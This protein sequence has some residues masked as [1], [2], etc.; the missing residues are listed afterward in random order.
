MGCGGSKTTPVS[1][2]SV[3]LEPKAFRNLPLGT[4]VVFDEVAPTKRKGDDGGGD[5]GAGG[6][7]DFFQPPM[8]VRLKLTAA[9]KSGG[10][11]GPRWVELER[12][13]GGGAPTLVRLA[14]FE[15]E[16]AGDA[17]AAAA[18]SSPPPAATS[19][20]T[21]AAAAAAAAADADDDNARELSVGDAVI[22][23]VRSIEREGSR[24]SGRRREVWRAAVAQHPDLQGLP[25]KLV[26]LGGAGES[27]PRRGAQ[28][29]TL[30]D[31]AAQQKTVSRRQF[32]CFS[33]VASLARD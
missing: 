27:K 26:E 24:G 16:A 19:P 3:Y 1:P 4:T 15:P 30:S 7:D 31:V 29:L 10:A 20:V 18:S 25:V 22:A 11:A 17:P 8:E 12:T 5:G 21:A 32:D 33:Y 13:V 9:D 2:P 28:V 6:E 23:C 14:A